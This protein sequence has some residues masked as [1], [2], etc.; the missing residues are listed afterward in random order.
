[1]KKIFLLLLLLAINLVTMFAQSSSYDIYLENAKKQF[2]EGNYESAGRNL[3]AYQSLTDKEESVLKSKIDKCLNLLEEADSLS[4]INKKED[5]I[6]CYYKVLDINPNDEKVSTKIAELKNSNTEKKLSLLYNVGNDIYQDG[7]RLKDSEIRMLF[8]GTQAYE[9]YESAS[10]VDMSAVNGCLYGFGVP[11]FIA[12]AIMQIGWNPSML[13]SG[14][15]YDNGCNLAGAG[16][17]LMGAGVIMMIIPP[18]VKASINTKIKKAVNIYNY[19]TQ[20]KQKV[21]L[22]VNLLPN[23]IGMKCVF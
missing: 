11:L 7:E 20:K 6:K 14:W 4:K 21:D 8:V 10:K 1:M 15:N 16:L 22:S 17:G 9:S 3:A 23:G 19:E 13:G 5:A 2:V 18:I 12:G